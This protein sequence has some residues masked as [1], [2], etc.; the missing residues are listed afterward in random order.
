[1]IGATVMGVV[2]AT[3]A[4][5]KH[6]TVARV[7]E[8]ASKRLRL[9]GEFSERLPLLQR[10]GL[11]AV[12]AMRVDPQVA[13]V[14]EG[15]RCTS[16]PDCVDVPADKHVAWPA[17]RCRSGGSRSCTGRD[18]SHERWASSPGVCVWRGGGGMALVP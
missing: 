14:Q 4:L 5:R 11:E 10:R 18:A 13:E 2:E 1:M 8:K 6:L 9:L 7:A 16:K 12:L 17:I 3:A 15:L